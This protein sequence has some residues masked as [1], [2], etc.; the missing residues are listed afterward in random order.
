M[1]RNT[2][3]SLE[4]VKKKQFLCEKYKPLVIKYGLLIVRANQGNVNIRS[5]VI[6]SQ[7]YRKFIGTLMLKVGIDSHLILPKSQV[8]SLYSREESND[9]ISLGPNKKLLL[10]PF[11]GLYNLQLSI[12]LLFKLFLQCKTCDI[13]ALKDKYD[14]KTNWN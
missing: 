7:I 14:G 3:N 11:H 10:T 2:I 8:Y 5:S 4:H 1:Q 12:L 6:S 9:I 13:L